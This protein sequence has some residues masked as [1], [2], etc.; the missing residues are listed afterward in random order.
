[1]KKKKNK[2]QKLTENLVENNY[3]YMRV[4]VLNVSFLKKYTHQME[5]LNFLF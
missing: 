1:M 4:G 2:K 5:M 3:I